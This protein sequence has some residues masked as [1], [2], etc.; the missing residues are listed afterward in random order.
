M[1][2]L[3]LACAHAPSPQTGFKSCM[4]MRSRTTVT[5]PSFRTKA[6]MLHCAIWCKTSLIGTQDNYSSVVILKICYKTSRPN[7][8]FT[9]KQFSLPCMYTT[10]FT[11]ENIL[12]AKFYSEL[13]APCIREL[14]GR[15]ALHLGIMCHIFAH[16]ACMQMKFGTQ[17]IC[18]QTKLAYSIRIC[19]QPSI[20]FFKSLD[21]I[22][23]MN[24]LGGVGFARQIVRLEH[25]LEVGDLTKQTNSIVQVRWYTVFGCAAGIHNYHI[26]HQ[27]LLCCA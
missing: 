16:S 2:L 21:G 24:A 8:C 26:G 7:M 27:L 3:H 12:S 6:K 11:C 18:S 20:P 14:P 15:L 19:F 1:G 5:L 13:N 25:A 22:Q 17:G 10:Y 23:S 9:C 4:Q